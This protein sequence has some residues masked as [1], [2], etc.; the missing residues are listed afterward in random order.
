MSVNPSL[1]EQLS[2][3]LA[4]ADDAKLCSVVAVIDR[5]PGHGALDCLIAP[6]RPRLARLKPPRPLTLERVL[7]LP[8]EPALVDQQ[9]WVAGS[10]RIPRSHLPALHGA[11]REG[12]EPGLVRSMTETLEGKTSLDVGA[13]LAAGRRLWP[14]AAATLDALLERSRGRLG[15]LSISLRLAAHLL[16]TG[17]K[18]VE[19]LW[20]LPPP[21]IL[22]FSGEERRRV[23]ALLQAASVRGAEAFAL[24]VDL[25]GARCDSPLLVLEP[26]LAG[27]SALGPRERRDCAARVADACLHELARGVADSLGNPE[28]P[29]DRIA[30]LVVRVMSSLE[31]LAEVASRLD[32]DR[33]M[34]RKLTRKTA[35]LAEE[36]TRRV[37]KEIKQAFERD[38]GT[39]PLHG[40]ERAARSVAR[41]RLVAP[42]LVIASKLRD[43]LRCAE[44]RY[45]SAFDA[46]LARRRQQ[47][48]VA[49]LDDPEI[50][51]RLR[52]IE[53]L[54]G[55]PVA[56]ELWERH[57]GIR[58]AR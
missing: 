28:A 54:F 38:D 56:V 10:Y 2:A 43:L 30:A 40:Y 11:V 26:L 58:R 18:L 27:E 36:T 5:Q 34:V 55:S 15:E 9:G 45:T 21:P 51:E 33:H 32:P 52:I 48:R 24:V 31:S 39:V 20:H 13:E 16:A 47:G 19:V 44:E 37:L 23:V 4:S 7:T 57:S 6:H 22:S 17:E 12:L 3:A 41:L 1:L 42:R 25:L 14:A 29:P 46:F 53:I 49:A 35:E 8:L 50:M